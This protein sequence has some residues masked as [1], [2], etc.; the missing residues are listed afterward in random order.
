M[1]ALP[2]LLPVLSQGNGFGAWVVCPG[3]SWGEGPAALASEASLLYWPRVKSFA[4]GITESLWPGRE[5]HV[6]L[7]IFKMFFYPRDTLDHRA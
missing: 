1:K 4:L 6:A 3:P 7:S 5:T 2:E